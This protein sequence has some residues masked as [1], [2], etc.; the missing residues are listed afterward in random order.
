MKNTHKLSIAA[1]GFLVTILGLLLY[2]I[3]TFS[4]TKQL[5]SLSDAYQKK[6][7]E[8]A[9]VELTQVID[10]LA[11]ATDLLIYELN[12][13]EEILQQ[14]NDPTYYTYWQNNRVANFN[15]MP[16]Y[17]NK[18]YVYDKRGVSLMGV[19]GERNSRIFGKELNTSIVSMINEK[20]VVERCMVLAEQYGEKN[21][22][23]YFCI[24]HD[25]LKALKTLQVFSYLDID[26]LVINRFEKEGITLNEFVDNVDFS[27]QSRKTITKMHD[28]TVET[29]FG[30]LLVSAAVIFIF[31]YILVVTIGKP[32]RG[33]SS[34][35][36]SLQ[37]FGSE[38]SLM[39][40][41]S[42][43]KI[44]EL[45]TVYESLNTYQ[46]RLEES[47][48]ELKNSEEY[49]RSLIENSSDVIIS[50]DNKGAIVYISPAVE[51]IL[52]YQSDEIIGDHILEYI[53]GS[54]I[55]LFRLSANTKE[56]EKYVF[57]HYNFR[58]KHKNGEWLHLELAGRV[59][60]DD[61]ASSTIICRDITERKKVQE[62]ISMAHDR[63]LEASRAKSNFLA[64]TSHELRTPL[65][66]I[67]GYSEII[68]EDLHS[69][70]FS[71][72]EDDIGKIHTAAKSLLHLID[73]VLDLSKIES[74]KMELEVGEMSVRELLTEVERTITPLMSRNSNTLEVN[75]SETTNTMF[76]D[77]NKLRQIIFNLL[78]NAAK[79]THNGEV[80]LDVKV[81][82]I[83][84]RDWI[85]FTITDTGVGMS[86]EQQDKVFEPFVQADASTTRKFGGTGLGLT[87]CR[88]FAHLMHGEISVQ[89]EEGVGSAFTLTLP[90]KI[91]NPEDRIFI[92]KAS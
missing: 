51:T 85:D 61:G 43:F 89:S 50:M 20:P 66:A 1:Y 62:A 3:L 88:S 77:R 25:L 56:N 39:P 16:T 24:Q 60:A 86:A 76:T 30:Y 48:E 14:I 28:L 47:S 41:F 58:V 78:N 5:D 13:W 91:R 81:R 46:M 74:G 23:G 71:N 65:N 11:K 33:L 15:L 31:L 2:V 22:L 36:N 34:H 69:K 37:V 12:N 52:G 73:E 10:K 40:G 6:H 83:N 90:L 26:S 80:T 49:F 79:F 9:K 44:S 38:K 59:I 27:V 72:A 19:D 8:L 32:L 42:F 7:Q 21:I 87:I 64:N 4:A 67:L 54:D 45:D 57:S 18:L 29:I 70:D 84:D 92:R 35:I 75:I 63:A 82:K 55:E 53:H 17:F 68:A